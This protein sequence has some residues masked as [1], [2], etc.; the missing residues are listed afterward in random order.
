MS[1]LNREHIMYNPL[2]IDKVHKLKTLIASE[3]ANIELLLDM[4]IEELFK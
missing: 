2:R 3:K 4:L 1:I